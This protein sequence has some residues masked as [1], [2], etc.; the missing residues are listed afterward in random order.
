MLGIKKYRPKTSKKLCRKSWNYSKKGIRNFLKPC[1]LEKIR[2]NWSLKFGRTG[3]DRLSLY[4][5]I[6]MT[7]SCTSVKEMYIS[8]YNEFKISHSPIAAFY[9]LVPLPYEELP[10]FLHPFISVYQ[11]PKYG[12]ATECALHLRSWQLLSLIHI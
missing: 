7:S 5:E 6:N 10:G 9:S 2:K 4:M 8:R 11:D 12:A 1:F 3:V